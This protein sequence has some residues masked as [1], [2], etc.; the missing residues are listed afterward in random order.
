ME[1]DAPQIK[2][3]VSQTDSSRIDSYLAK[4]FNNVSRSTITN[5]LASGK[6]KVN[7]N[8]VTKNNT[9]IC[10]GDSIEVTIPKP[11]VQSDWGKEN[12]ALDI[13]F[14]DNDI[15]VINKPSNLTMHPGAGQSSGTLANALAYHDNN[16]TTLPRM[17]IVHRLDKN[18]SGILVV[19]KTAAAHHSL[20]SQLQQRQMTK[21]YHTLVNGNVIAG[22]TIDAPIGR[23][24]KQRTIMAINHRGKEAI[25]HYLVLKKYN[26]CTLLQVTIET[27]RT[28]Q[29]RVHMQHIKHTIIGDRTYGRAILPKGATPEIAAAISSFP[30]QALHAYQLEFAHPIS[31]KHLS[32][33]SPYPEDFADLIELLET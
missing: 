33:T 4:I 26:A 6:I 25:S 7:S 3:S 5:W 18:T 24:P 10:H 22:G 20:V 23:H 32:F 29:I 21:I 13:I 28:H 12:I 16:L 15:L 27:G 17:G 19:A 9:K 8:T 30:R 1:N 14:E 31:Q 2:F 11:V